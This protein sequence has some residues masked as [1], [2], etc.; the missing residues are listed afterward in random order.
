MDR[1]IEN[2][3]PNLPPGCNIQLERVARERVL[4][5]VKAVLSDLNH[6]IPETIQT[7]G[8]ESGLPLTFGH[9]ISATDLSAVDVLRRHSWSE[10]KALAMQ[11]P[12][13]VDPDLALLRKALPRIALRS[14]PELLRSL[15][16]D[17]IADE[18]SDGSMAI[19]MHYLRWGKTGAALGLNTLAESAR[20]W[21]TNP[22]IVADAV[23]IA[24]WRLNHPTTPLRDIALP[25][26]CWLTLHAQYGSAEI[27]AGLGL[28]TLES[29]GPTGQG[30]IHAAELKCYI[31]LI[32]FRKDD[33]VFSPT[34]RYRDYPISATKLH[35]ES[36]STIS[37]RST[38]G[39][40]YLY[41][42]E[43]GYTILFFARLER[44]IDGETAPFTYLGP[45]KALLSAEEERP[46]RMVWELEYPIPAGLLEEAI[47]AV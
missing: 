24:A 17:N 37:Q 20:R 43:R 19:A 1:E 4:A 26:P 39:Q 44:Q 28:S 14:D 34:T 2:D 46:M 29:A 25:F 33:R 8:Q 45:A 18:R 7:W 5:K 15:L 10:W 21:H 3:F 11:Q 40:N 31:H 22:S 16:N 6:F 9:F 32:T 38:T 12:L 30:V 23:E 36:Q 35:W 41:F 13:P 27:K 47:P 42:R